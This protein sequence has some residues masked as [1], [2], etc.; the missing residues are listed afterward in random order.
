MLIPEFLLGDYRAVRPMARKFVKEVLEGKSGSELRMV[1]TRST[2][3]LLVVSSN[4]GHGGE[5]HFQMFAPMQ[6]AVESFAPNEM[7]LRLFDELV[8]SCWGAL[9]LMDQ[10]STG[11]VQLDESRS[12]TFVESVLKC[13][14]V[15]AQQGNRF[16]WSSYGPT[17]LWGVPTMLHVELHQLG[18][19]VEEI[20]TPLR[21][22]DLN[23]LLSRHAEKFGAILANVS[24][25]S[26][27]RRM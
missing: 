5:A 27:M 18:L 8:A 12:R 3:G 11:L 9:C 1:D 4:P 26:V 6:A 19:P 10:N 16:A 21:D 7:R 24:T 2:T 25:E 13:W 20:Q 14:P 23:A 15:Y 17:V 22:N